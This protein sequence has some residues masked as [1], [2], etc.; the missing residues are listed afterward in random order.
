MGCVRN[1]IESAEFVTGML[2]GSPGTHK[3]IFP[4]FYSCRAAW[5]KGK[6][7]ILFMCL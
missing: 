4:Q 1:L 5:A 3:G 2:V 7:K 6:R